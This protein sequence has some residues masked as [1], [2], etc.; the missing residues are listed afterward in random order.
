MFSLPLRPQPAR[1]PPACSPSEMVG[2]KAPS[3]KARKSYSC[4]Q[5]A[6][7]H[8]AAPACRRFFCHC[9]APRGRIHHSRLPHP[10]GVPLC[11]A[12]ATLGPLCCCEAQLHSPAQATA[13][14]ARAC[15]STRAHLIR[16][17]RP[18]SCGALRGC[19]DPRLFTLFAPHGCRRGS[20]HRIRACLPSR[21]VPRRG[22]AGLCAAATAA[23]TGSS[24]PFKL[25]HSN[26]FLTP[27]PS[28]LPRLL[29]TV[30]RSTVAALS[31]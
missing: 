1:Q 18:P 16:M 13:A 5:A 12:V 17:R 7:T 26:Q 31:P 27:P 15:V 28:H 4:G 22:G 11:R 25:A 30:L 3:L 19:P 21:R 20:R 14:A 10:D 6:R 9:R 24:C 8:A 23:P 2:L 29:R